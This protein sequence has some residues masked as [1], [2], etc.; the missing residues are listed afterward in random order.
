MINNGIFLNNQ[1]KLKKEFNDKVESL[2]G[3]KLFNLD[4]CQ[5][6]ISAKVINDWVTKST[7]NLITK[8]VDEGT[9]NM[10]FKIK[11]FY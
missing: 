6:Q 10:H 3:A 2:F 4:F 8:M 5:P 11:I 7:K 1:Y 9:K